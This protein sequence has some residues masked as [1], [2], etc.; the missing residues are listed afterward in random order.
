[1]SEKTNEKVSMC[2]V[3]EM[4][5]KDKKLALN[6]MKDEMFALRRMRQSPERLTYLLRLVTDYILESS[7]TKICGICGLP[8][9][10]DDQD[11]VPVGK[12]CFHSACVENEDGDEEELD[13]E[14]I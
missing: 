10:S 12:V 4:P 5:F 1:M 8:I 9:Y 6:A 3:A 11:Y 13:E 14:D 7:Y 2:G